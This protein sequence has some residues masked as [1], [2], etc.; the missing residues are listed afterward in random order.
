MVQVGFWI[1][2]PSKIQ[3]FVSTNIGQNIAETLQFED[4][5]VIIL[6]LMCIFLCKKIEFE[7]NEIFMN[8]ER[9]KEKRKTIPTKSHSVVEGFKGGPF[10]HTKTFFPQNV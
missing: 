2:D 10:E 6:F 1:N 3:K 5:T 4:L 7:L 8:V 9:K